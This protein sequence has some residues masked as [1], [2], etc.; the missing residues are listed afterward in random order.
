[1]GMGMEREAA[2]EKVVVEMRKVMTENRN[3]VAE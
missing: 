3:E 1:M 2:E